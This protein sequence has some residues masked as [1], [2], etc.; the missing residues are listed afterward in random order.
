MTKPTKTHT[1]GVDIGGTKMSAV[2]FDGKNVVADYLLATP[3][4]DLE[5]FMIMLKALIEPLLD[6]A[7]KEKI[8]IKG[9][10][11]AVAAELDYQEN[12]IVDAPNLPLLNGQKLSVNLAARLGMATIKMDNDAH[13]FLTAEAKLGAGQRHHNIL[14]V[15]IGTG[16]GGAWLLNDKIYLGSHGGSIGPGWLVIDY[17]EGIR[18]E[19]AYHKLAQNN[20]ATLAEEAY[21]GDILAEKS[22]Q[23]FGHYLGITL[24]NAVNL[25]DPELII[26]GGGAV[27][28]SD[29]F[30]STTKRA[31]RQYIKNPETKKVRI[32]KGKLGANAGAI[33][34][35]LL[36]S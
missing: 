12:R 20:P 28:S 33:G 1:I 13:C 24:A 29:L 27:E 6:R 34:A 9:V 36:V 32:V 7:K 17:K 23:E 4:D 2:L 14:G 10:G 3:K 19:E 15:I 16:I 21:R 31:M 35:A 22:Y 5:H 26:I 8:P 30:I 18:L 11:V 25:L